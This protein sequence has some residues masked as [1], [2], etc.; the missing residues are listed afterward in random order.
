VV[1]CFGRLRFSEHEKLRSPLNR[2]K[3]IKEGAVALWIEIHGAQLLF[4]PESC[5]FLTRNGFE[6]GITLKIAD[7]NYIQKDLDERV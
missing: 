2:L 6:A 4:H 3:P 1:L 7:S 5:G